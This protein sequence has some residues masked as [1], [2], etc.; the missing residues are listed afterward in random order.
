MKWSGLTCLTI[1]SKRSDSKYFQFL[2]L[3]LCP[4]SEKLING[5]S[6]RRR[7]F[8]VSHPTQIQAERGTE[9]SFIFFYFWT[10]FP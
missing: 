4:D 10:I 7:L 1:A 9:Q 2:A 3:D 6:L 5:P 8:L